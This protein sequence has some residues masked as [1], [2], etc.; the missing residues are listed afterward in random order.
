[1]PLIVRIQIAILTSERLPLLKTVMFHNPPT[2]RKERFRQI[3]IIII[4]HSRRR[5]DLSIT[6]IIVTK[7]IP[8]RLPLL[9][10]KIINQHLRPHHKTEAIPIIQIHHQAE[11]AVQVLIVPVRRAEAADQVPVLIVLQE[12]VPDHRVAAAEVEAIP[13]ED[14]TNYHINKDINLIR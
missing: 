12:A 6:T 9:R 3:R 8:D 5:R 2:I 7:T 10:H 4:I 14:N 13:V 11:V 1:M